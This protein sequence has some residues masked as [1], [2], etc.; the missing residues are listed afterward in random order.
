MIEKS[1]LLLISPSAAQVKA[2][3]ESTDLSTEEI[4]LLFGLADGSSWRKK[5]IQKAGSNNKR[6]LKPMEY[7]MLLLL[8]DTHPNLKIIE[9]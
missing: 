1:K 8:S 2:A 4:A 5:E 3:R 7:E 6:L 9:K